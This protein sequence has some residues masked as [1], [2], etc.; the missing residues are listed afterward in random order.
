MSLAEVQSRGCGMGPKGTQHKA[1]GDLVEQPNRL[2]LKT[3]PNRM[4]RTT[5]PQNV[6]AHAF[7][8]PRES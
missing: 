6:T 2:L 1:T 5:A 8:R 7:D 4:A 3:Q